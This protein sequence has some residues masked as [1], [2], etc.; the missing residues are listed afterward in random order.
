MAWIGKG[1]GEVR[2]FLSPPGPGRHL[3]NRCQGGNLSALIECAGE[4]GGLP[5]NTD[6]L[7]HVPG[8][9]QPF[10]ENPQGPDLVMALFGEVAA[11]LVL[12]MSA[13][14]RAMLRACA[15]WPAAASATA[16]SVRAEA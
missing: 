1:A 13:A 12:G 3:G 11:R 8:S 10:G 6:G 7:F 2:S 14:C 4:V 15:S 16:T 9:G 5:G